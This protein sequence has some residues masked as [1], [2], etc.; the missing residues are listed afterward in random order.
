MISA[1]L[2]KLKYIAEEMQIVFYLTTFLNDQFITRTLARHILI[3]AENFIEHARGL[4]R[5][6]IDAR[7]NIRNF[8]KTKENYASTFDEYF[9]LARH[10]LG[11]HVQDFDFGKRIEIWN[12]IEIVKVGWFVEGAQEIYRGLA[13]LSLPCYIEYTEPPELAD[14]S[15]QEILIQYQRAIGSRN[16]VE[17]A[18]DSLAITR[19]NTSAI[20]N[21]TPV[22]ERAGQLA[23]I[24]RWIAIQNDLLDKFTTYRRISRILKTRIIT[25]IVSFCDCLVTRPTPNCALQNMDGLDKLIVA[26][27]ESSSAIDDFVAATNFHGELQALRCIRDKIGAHVEISETDALSDLLTELDNYDLREGLDFYERVNAAFAKT[28]R[29]IFFLHM[30]A[31]D[32]QRLYGV[33][34][35]RI[36]AVEYADTNDAFPSAPPMPPPINDGTAYWTNLRR[37]L[38]GD[39]AQKGDARQFFWYAFAGSQVTESIYEIERFSSGQSIIKHEFRKAHKFLSSTLSDGLSDN[40]FQGVVEL[41]LSCRSGWPY[42][43][44]E[45]LI[46]Y[47]R[48]APINRQWLICYALGEIGSAPHA[49]AREFLQSCTHSPLWLIRFEAVLAEFKTFV[50][51][52]GC[53]RINHKG[54]TKD[55]YDV[56]VDSMLAP[57]SRPE[58]LICLLAFASLLSG[59]GFEAFALPFQSHYSRL[60]IN[61]E[62]ECSHFL[63]DDDNKSKESKLK[64][65]IQTHDY[66][67]VCLLLALDYDDQDPLRAALL[68]S[69]C[70][71]SIV[72]TNHD[73]ATRHLAMSFLLKKDYCTALDIVQGIASRNPE[74]VEIQILTAEI[75]G[76]TPGAKEEALYKIKNIRRAYRLTHDFEMRLNAIEEEI[77]RRG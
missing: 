53:F 37:W 62:V 56:L 2:E 59:P 74:L 57:M 54:E 28:C 42:P 14:Q 13:S 24:R 50:K 30:Y 69:C 18:T 33:S 1:R 32:G 66:V 17:M 48:E 5:P 22:H 35:S 71:G 65:L 6:L 31:A 75:L 76:D 9:K 10:R 77:E 64:Q 27:G 51:T 19:N 38:D 40:D 23:L 41:I 44:S 47:G 52:E 8:H 20:L 61:I 25:D 16:W 26:S 70:N 11:A 63:K 7:C 67:G 45:V 4:R 15:I 46:R 36:S 3:R 68:D 21:M 73:Q 12:D 58:R 34:S 55:C 39:D 29:G 43:L 72:T 49:A 60:Q